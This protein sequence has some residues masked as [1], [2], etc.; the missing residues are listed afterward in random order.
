VY[1]LLDKIHVSLGVCR[2]SIVERKGKEEMC[3]GGSG[4]GNSQT[5][6]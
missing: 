2:C 4:D 3:G 5:F 6:G 1:G